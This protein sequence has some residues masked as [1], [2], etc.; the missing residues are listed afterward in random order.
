MKNLFTI[1]L[2]MIVML[3]LGEIETKNLANSHRKAPNATPTPIAAPAPTTSAPSPGS[4]SSS[5]NTTK[6]ENA[7]KGTSS[8]KH[9]R[10]ISGKRYSYKKLVALQDVLINPSRAKTLSNKPL[11]KARNRI[12]LDTINLP[13]KLNT[14][15]IKVGIN[16]IGLLRKDFNSIDL[17]Y[18]Y[19]LRVNGKEVDNF[20]GTGTIAEDIDFM[21][22]QTGLPSL[23]KGKNIFELDVLM[24]ADKITGDNSFKLIGQNNAIVEVD[25]FY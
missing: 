2:A 20:G 3:Q 19:I 14:V 7:S 11:S 25:G 12:Y 10:K 21:W 9:A 23:E 1:A 17:G 15:N 22:V 5:S 24:D 6:K 16:K 4:T 18:K 13:S 8:V